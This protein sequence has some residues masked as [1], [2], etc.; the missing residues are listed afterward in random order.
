MMRLA[1]I[2]WSVAQSLLLATAMLAFMVLMPWLG[3]RPVSEAPPEAIASLPSKCPA[4]RS[5]RHSEASTT[6]PDIYTTHYTYVCEWGGSVENNPTRLA[7]NLGVLVGSLASAYFLSY[8]GRGFSM[9]HPAE[10]DRSTS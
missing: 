9:R 1:K 7:I 3:T 4:Y 6:A 5:I 2:V 10:P 8:T